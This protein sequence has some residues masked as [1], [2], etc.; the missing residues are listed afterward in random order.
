M[1]KLGPYETII[2]HS[3][4]WVAL[5]IRLSDGCEGKTE[6]CRLY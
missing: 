4:P 1:R 3:K 2:I 6:T 5:S